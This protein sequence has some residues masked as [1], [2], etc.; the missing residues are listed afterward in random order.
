[1]RLPEV[2]SIN[3]HGFPKGLYFTGQSSSKLQQQ[4]TLAL[5]GATVQPLG[6]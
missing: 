6:L 3:P 1:M 4:Q 2:R 5:Q